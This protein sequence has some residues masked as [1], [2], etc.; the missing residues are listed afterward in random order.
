M[1]KGGAREESN[2]VC[3]SLARLDQPDGVQGHDKDV[4]VTPSEPG[5]S[6]KKRKRLDSYI[7]SCLTGTLQITH[8][9]LGQEA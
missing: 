6:S 7:V 8:T 9:S 3:R 4:Q 5:M 1:G 2:E